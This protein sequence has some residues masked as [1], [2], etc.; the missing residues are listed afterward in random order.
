MQLLFINKL[1]PFFLSTPVSLGMNCTTNSDC[2]GSTVCGHDNHCRNSCTGS[3]SC[4]NGHGIIGY[5]QEG[6]GVCD[7]HRDCKGSLECGVGACGRSGSG[8]FN[9]CTQGKFDLSFSDEKGKIIVCVEPLHLRLDFADER[10]LY[11][12]NGRLLHITVRQ[13]IFQ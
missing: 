12:S 13:M 9:C 2:G 3:S 8:R 6:E 1:I 10:N 4:C 11:Y 7:T 5:C